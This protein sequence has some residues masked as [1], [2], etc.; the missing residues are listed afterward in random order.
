MSSFQRVVLYGALLVF[1]VAAAKPLIDIKYQKGTVF[2]QLVNAKRDLARLDEEW[3]TLNIRKIQLS[4]ESSVNAII[5]DKL[6]MHY[7]KETE[8]LRLQL[9]SGITRGT[10]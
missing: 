10:Q 9:P 5:S 4:N 2:N 6:N 8:I 7:P 1:S 3:R